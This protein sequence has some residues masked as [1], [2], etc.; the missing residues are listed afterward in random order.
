MRDG[1]EILLRALRPE[2]WA[3]VRRVLDCRLAAVRVVLENLHHPHNMS[4]VLRSCEAFGVQR[5][6]A[7]ETVEDFTVSRRITLGSHKW[8]TLTRHDTFETCAQEL[9]R[10]GFRLYAA[11]LDSEAIPLDQIPVDEPVA[12]VLG[13]EK[14]G[15]SV[16]A[17]ALCDGAYTIP[18]AGFVQSLN[19]SVAAAVTL[20]SLTERVRKL[21]AD[22]GLLN[23][24]EKEELLAAWLP[25]SI[26][27][28]TRIVKAAG[29][30]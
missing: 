13:N 28:G 9:R 19:V 11:M 20:H 12:V 22:G 30:R 7:V 17:R 4:A 15:V 24:T 3:K 8:L 2:R 18:M 25:K 14:E 23:E 6:H 27:A 10:L 5:V 29:N 21:R 1:R 16:R 26:R